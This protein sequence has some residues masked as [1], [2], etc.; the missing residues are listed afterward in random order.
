LKISTIRLPRSIFAC[1]AES[2]SDP[3]CANAA[4]SRNWARSPLSWPAT[5]FIALT[6]AAEPTRET[7]RP[8][9]IA[10]RTPW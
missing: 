2:S 3:N 5:C 10:G 8:T 4:S 9:E 1:D 6:C 7:D